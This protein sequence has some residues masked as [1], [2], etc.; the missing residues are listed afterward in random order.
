MPSIGTP[1]GSLVNAGFTDPALSAQGA[2]GER[3]TAEIL[4]RCCLNGAT[5][6][7]DLNIPGSWA[8]IDH[9]VVAGQRLW[10][11]DSKRWKPGF[12]WRVGTG[13]ARRGMELFTPADKTTMVM[14]RDRLGRWLTERGVTPRWWPATVVVWPSNGS[15]MTLW[16]LGGMP[17]AGVV[18]PAR[19][20]S[21]ARERCRRRA[22]PALLAALACLVRR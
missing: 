2:A 20:T 11:I 13:P 21:L 8:N 10:L 1:A 16:A 12:Y 3:A 7:H 14:A 17:G 19:F 4:D 15:K 18:T 5:V 22:D 9:L 6:L